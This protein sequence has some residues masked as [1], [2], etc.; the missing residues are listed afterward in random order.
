MDLTMDLHLPLL[1]NPNAPRLTRNVTGRDHTGADVTIS[2]VEER[3]LTIFLNSQEI[4][5]PAHV[6]RRGH[7]YRGRL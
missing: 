3:P 4:V 2:V 1:P 5:K 6:A 7:H